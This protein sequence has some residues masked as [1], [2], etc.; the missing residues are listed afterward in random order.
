MREEASQTIARSDCRILYS[1]LRHGTDFDLSKLAIEP[2]HF[3]HTSV[4][5]FRRKSCAAVPA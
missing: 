5:R 2:G 4:R 1:M 3:E